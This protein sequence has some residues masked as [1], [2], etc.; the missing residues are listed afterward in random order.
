M[1]F[2]PEGQC[3]R[4]WLRS[5]CPSGTKYILRAEALIKLALRAPFRSGCLARSAGNVTRE[6]AA[7]P[8]RRVAVKPTLPNLKDVMGR[9][10]AYSGCTV[11]SA[12]KGLVCFDL[13]VAVT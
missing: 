12:S 1:A 8:P 9:L 11:S 6:E 10:C 4:A 7:N 3:D 2:V 5:H 13:A